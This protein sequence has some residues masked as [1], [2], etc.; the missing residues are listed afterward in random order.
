MFTDQNKFVEYKDLKWSGI[1]KSIKKSSNVLQPL[2]EA[3]TNSMEAIRLRQNN[4]DS[5]DAYINIILDFKFDLLGE[6]LDFVSLT[7]EDNGI[8]FDE[9]N[10][11]RLI[12]F[13]D[14]TKGFNN[15]G[16]GRIQ[17][18]HTFKQSK[19]E[20]VYKEENEI[21]ERSFVLSKLQRFIQNNTIIYNTQEPKK[22]NEGEDIKTTL[23]M[24]ETWL[25]KDAKEFVKLGC[26]DI[27]KALISHYL[28]ALCNLKS[29]LPSI[30]IVYLIGGVEKDRERIVADDIPNPSFNDIHISVPLCR[31][32]ED[33]KRIEKDAEETI[34]INV[35]PYK[36]NAEALAV[37]EIKITS[38]GEI[39]DTTKVKLTCID[40]NAVLDD[41][42]YL[43]LLSS[44]Y[45]DNLDGDERGNI[46]ILDKTEFK[47]RA[48]TQGFIEE[49]IVLNDIQDEVNKKAGE[50]YSEISEQKELLQQ[51]IEELKN[52]Y[53]LSEEALVDADINDSVE[54]I[55]S[56]AYVYDAKLIAKQ[57]AE[58]QEKKTQIE[59][60]D[61]TSETYKDDLEKMVTELTK[62]I[63][64]Q[65]KESLSR[66]VTHRSLV[67]EL[68]DKLIKR[69]TLIQNVSDRKIDEKLI[70]NLLFMQHSK[71]AAMSDIWML[72]EDYLY[73][74]GYS[75]HKLSEIKID[76]KP[77]FKTEIDE[78]EKR[79]LNYLGEHRQSK[80]PDIL[81]FPS[82]HKCVIIELKS[83][84]ANL[85]DYLTQINKY[86]SF[87]RS[88]TTDDFYIDTFYGY[89]I[90]EALEPRDV[91][92]A[93]NDFKYDPKFNFCYRPSKSIAC[94]W[95]ESGR[96]DGSIY[97]EAL[98]F[99]VMLKRALQRNES[100]KNRLFPHQ[101]E[102]SNKDVSENDIK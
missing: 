55:L 92:A 59:Q 48:K 17:M 43:F 19:Y 75:E 57:D 2:F 37:S 62:T 18:V 15:R 45:F 56:K 72:N 29:T 3:F 30:N 10:F 53:M 76:E 79:Y 39:S 61:T 86:A 1:L 93:D 16:S 40:P 100:F 65:C 85:S 32:S 21:K 20:S 78:E 28:L 69:E 25:S 52:T 36:I 24:Y 12:V 70:H 96:H 7:I 22:A 8:G 33:M 31:M 11:N 44:D 67:L 49:Q 5:F 91:R 80:R 84:D 83:L 54:D 41:S 9:E 77:L 94:L 97:T 6:S 87:I 50:L 51:R 99:S 74:R 58:Y 102:D 82:E 66:Y 68:F 89:L 34:D 73:Y 47:K 90:G 26:V 81:L 27:K 46:E 23:K 38:K 63:P 64:L 98:S 71:N 42:R 60:L 88:Y 35:M 95:D 13:K 4:G 101:K 14:D